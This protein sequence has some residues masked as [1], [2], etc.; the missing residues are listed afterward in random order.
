MILL[1]KL[2]IYFEMIILSIGLYSF[3]IRNFILD[4]SARSLVKCCIGHGGSYEKCTVIGET[5]HSRRVYLE[6]NEP[7]RTDES[8]KNREQ[9]L[10]HCGQSPLV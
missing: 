5:V 1:M 3:V 8:F 2:K 7:L 6:L 4:A 10:H 9:S